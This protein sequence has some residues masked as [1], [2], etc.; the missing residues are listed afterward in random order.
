MFS[1][2]VDGTGENAEI[3][4]IGDLDIEV[5]DIIE[6]IMLALL[7]YKKV[8]FNFNG[9]PFVDS[10]GIGL[11]INLVETLKKNKDDAQILIKNIQPLVKEV[12]EML[13]LGEILGDRVRLIGQ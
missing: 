10:T 13:Q 9:V 12:F 3:F 1:Y 7:N 4:F 6:E 2:K 11:L 8:E 5:S